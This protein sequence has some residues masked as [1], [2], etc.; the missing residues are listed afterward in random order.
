[1]AEEKTSKTFFF[2]ILNL[3]VLRKQKKD[4]ESF[5]KGL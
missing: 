1:V 4:K 3:A 5:S 2:V